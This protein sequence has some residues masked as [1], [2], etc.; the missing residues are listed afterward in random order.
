MR[1][2][3]DRMLTGL[4]RLVLRGFFRSLEVEGRG[5]L[6]ADRPLLIVANHFNALV[7]AVLVVHALGRLPRFVATS[8]LWR[9]VVTRPLLWL[10]GLVP[11]HR[12]Q[13]SRGE[14]HHNRA[15]FVSCHEQLARGKTVALFPEGRVSPVPRPQTLRTGAARI[16][17]GA[18]TSGATGLAIVPVGLVYED[19]LALRSRAL[20]RIGEPVD[21]DEELHRAGDTEATADDPEAV[22][23][24]TAQIDQRLRGLA[25]TYRDESEA[26]VL[27]HA[28][29]IAL[30][31]PD[32]LPPPVVPLAQRE[33]LA[34]RLAEASGPARD[35]VIDAVARYHLG[36]S[37]LGL[38]DAY[39][40]AGYRI[41]RLAGLL[42]STMLRLGLV[43]PIALVGAVVNALPY[44]IVHWTGRLVGNVA[45]RA[46][47]RMLAGVV[48][49]PTAWLVTAWLAPWDTWTARAAIV[50]LVPIAGLVAVRA[51]E[52]AITV[53]ATWRGWIGL[54]ERGAELERLRGERARVVAAVHHTAG[55]SRTRIPSSGRDSSE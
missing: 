26:A 54:L 25:P 4:V 42:A 41:R 9:P 37:L 1:A 5:H 18:R 46:S 24:L 50:V 45:M 12:P 35:R 49:F 16:A 19:K 34:R 47:V 36:L 31:E 53:H 40:F 3:I 33:D 17:L 23:R 52:E 29:E 15:M 22:R 39:L 43:A 2:V 20:V 7:D 10:A 27:G 14:A 38:R 8:T 48:L 11:V 32:R 30:R 51:L 6:P 28:A 21:L 44:W 55:Q 13:D